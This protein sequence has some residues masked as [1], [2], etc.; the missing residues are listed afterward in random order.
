[1]AQT[2]RKQSQIMGSRK[3]KEGKGQN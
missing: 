2:K 1:V 3:T